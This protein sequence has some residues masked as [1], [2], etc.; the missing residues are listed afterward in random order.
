MGLKAG[1][2]GR[3]V[4][5]V[6]RGFLLLEVIGRGWRLLLLLKTK[7]RRQ[8]AC[9]Q[10]EDYFPLNQFFNPSQMFPPPPPEL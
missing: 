4:T 9:L 8:R 6:G 10:P 1:N 2:Q 5:E 3:L 7:K